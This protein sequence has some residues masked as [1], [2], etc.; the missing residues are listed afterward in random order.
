[1]NRIVRTNA[2][3]EREHLGP[4]GWFVAHPLVSSPNASSTRMPSRPKDHSHLGG[5]LLSARPLSFPPVA[6]GDRSLCDSGTPD[7]A[8]M[9]NVD[10]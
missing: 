2:R 6:R 4:D 7:F 5:P 1:M 3:G 10:R 9:R 8:R